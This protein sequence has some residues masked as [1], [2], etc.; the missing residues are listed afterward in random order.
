M[1]S[2]CSVKQ[3]AGRSTERKQKLAEESRGY[4][5]HSGEWPDMCLFLYRL[6]H[7]CYFGKYV[8]RVY[9]VPGTWINT[10]CFLKAVWLWNIPSMFWS[11]SRVQLGRAGAVVTQTWKK[12]EDSSGPLQK[13]PNWFAGMHLLESFSW[14]QI[15]SHTSFLQILQQRCTR[16]WDK[17]L[18][19]KK[20]GIYSLSN[21]FP[22]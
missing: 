2:L 12:P 3:Q 22:M 1:A 20:T 14:I 21:S 16:T 10:K 15:T 18:P 4:S 6:Q 8:L 13:P 19:R 11:W 9:H 7:C 17:L 5:G